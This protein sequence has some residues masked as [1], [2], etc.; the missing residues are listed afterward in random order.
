VALIPLALLG[1]ASGG[2]AGAADVGAAAT[3]ELTRVGGA[4]QIT[5]D[6]ERTHECEFVAD[7]PL[8]GNRMSDVNAMRAMRN[9]AGRLGANLVLLVME[10]DTTIG[11]AE[12]YLCAD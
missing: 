6:A 12:G 4:V 2:S 7:V 10:T 8:Q 9:E 1:C 5:E 3:V 11:R